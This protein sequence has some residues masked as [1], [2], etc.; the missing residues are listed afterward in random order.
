MRTFLHLATLLC[1]VILGHVKG[2][3]IICHS[4]QK[5]A[6]ISECDLQPP[7][8]CTQEK[9]YCKITQEKTGIPGMDMF[10]KVTTTK[11]CSSAAECNGD[12]VSI[13]EPKKNIWCC[14][15]NLCNIFENVGK[16]DTSSYNSH[17][18]K[19]DPLPL[20]HTIALVIYLLY[21]A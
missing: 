14:R 13:W 18:Q 11:G 20:I 16:S 12:D 6:N 4:C 8:N 10:S 21:C 3:S 1:L 15:E 7:E 9:P 17:A 5:F 2:Q 19:K